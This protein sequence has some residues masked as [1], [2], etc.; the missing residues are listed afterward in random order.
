MRLSPL[1][2][3]LALAGFAAIAPFRSIAQ[4][5]P[6][7][8]KGQALAVRVD[9]LLPPLGEAAP[10]REQSV[11]YTVPGSPVSVKLIGTNAVILVQVTPFYADAGKLT[12]V[13]QAQ[14]WVHRTEGG[15][16]YR[17]RIDTVSVNFGESVYYYP[18]GV[19][20]DGSSPIRVE[21]SV[22]K[23]SDVPAQNS[24]PSQ[25]PPQNPP[26]AAPAPGPDAP[27]K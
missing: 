12:L 11:K 2:F 10:W 13:T 20:A 23:A 8:L 24:Q 22:I 16:S 15:M 1:L 25:N 6:E 17:T 27:R 18:L 7:S 5:L 9:A 4:D 3:G 26:Q 19:A 21:I 14:I